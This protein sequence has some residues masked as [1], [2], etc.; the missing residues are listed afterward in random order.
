MAKPHDDALVIM[1]DVANYEV[2][3][4]IVD[5]GSLVD[6]IF[7]NT[8]NRMGIKRTEIVGPP[9]P[10][11]AFTGETTMS[12][13]TLKLPIFA[14]RVS[15]IVEFTVFNRPAVY[16]IVLGTPWLYQMRAVP[17]TYHQ[18]IKFPMPAGVE[19]IKGNQDISKTCYLANHR[20]KL[21]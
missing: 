1:L 19:T 10:L 4:I 6:L 14:S 8:L 3:R 20:M 11:I 2:T 16:N 13:G 15:K 12:L 18:C 5:T 21:Q 7:L 17:S 9:A